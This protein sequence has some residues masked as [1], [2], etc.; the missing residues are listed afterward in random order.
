M[1]L[2]TLNF[3]GRPDG[4]ENNSPL[5][6]DTKPEKKEIVKEPYDPRMSPVII[7]HLGREDSELEVVFPDKDIEEL[8]K[9]FDSES[10]FYYSLMFTLFPQMRQ[11]EAI[12]KRK[13]IPKKVVTIHRVTE[14]TEAP[15]VI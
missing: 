8:V 4:E 7:H 3:L 2:L 15:V 13:F 9:Q 11:R 1:Y 6:A 14:D 10:F 12:R 5:D